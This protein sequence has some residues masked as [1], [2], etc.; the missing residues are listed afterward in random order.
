MVLHSNNGS[1]VFQYMMNSSAVDVYNQILIGSSPQANGVVPVYIMTL[2]N[3]FH[4][5]RLDF[6]HA[7]TVKAWHL[8]N[9]TAENSEIRMVFGGDSPDTL[10]S[11]IYASTILN[12]VIRV[13]R[14]LA[15]NGTVD[16]TYGFPCQTS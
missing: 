6:S 4:L 7:T 14:I 13:S 12:R 3:H 2:H 16:W 10:E 11:V 5:L 9:N 15:D 1:I 8:F